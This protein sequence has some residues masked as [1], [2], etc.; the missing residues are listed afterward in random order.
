MKK[1][2]LTNFVIIFL[3]CLSC[4]FSNVDAAADSLPSDITISALLEDHPTVRLI[5]K[6]LPEFEYQTGIKVNIEVIP[7]EMMT[8]KARETLDRKST[9]YDVYMDGWVNAVEWASQGNLEPLDAY[10]DNSDIRNYLDI[11]DFIKAYIS[12][13]RYK[14]KLYGLP[15]YG[16]STFL[17]YRKDIFS[18]YGIKPPESMED[19]EV[20]AKKIKENC[21]NIYAV[22]L[23]GREGVHIVYA[24]ASFLWAFGGRWLNEKGELDLDTPEAVKSAIFFT[25]LLRNY[26]PP[27]SASF[28]WNENRDI[29][30]TGRAAMSI[31]ATVNGAFNENPKYSAVAGKTGYLP[32]PKHSKAILKGGQSSLV[33]HQMYI[34]KHSLNKKQA[35]TFISWATSKNVQMKS[36]QI[37]PNSGTTSRHVINSTIFQEKFGAFTESMLKSLKNGNSNY[38]PIIPESSL[39]FEKV[40][41]ALSDILLGNEKAEEA[42]K[43]VNHELNEIITLK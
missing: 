13:A 9:L 16:E 10:I 28:G 39:I 31:D 34:N 14:E 7:F 22:T 12:D 20:A 41:K 30:L 19:I 43:K 42:L 27:A 26:G 36:M 1:I 37:E 11:E 17:Y 40:G 29:F 6:L 38:L 21:K 5:A 25:D 35:F 24:W 23:R 8:K 32:T 33:T 4:F 2:F 3:S 15:V 18:L